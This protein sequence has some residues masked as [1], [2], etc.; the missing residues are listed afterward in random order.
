[1]H[2]W[3]HIY[4]GD[5]QIDKDVAAA[6]CVEFMQTWQCSRHRR[7]SLGGIMAWRCILFVFLFLMFNMRVYDVT[8]SKVA[9]LT[10]VA[11]KDVVRSL[12]FICVFISYG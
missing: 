6:S 5:V 1:M 9:P 8:N 10:G 2:A 3:L 12:Y 7:G 11:P 4:Y